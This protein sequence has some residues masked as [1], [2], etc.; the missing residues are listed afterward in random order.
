MDLVDREK[1]PKLTE[2]ERNLLETCEMPCS[3]EEWRLA[4]NQMKWKTL[5]S[6]GLLTKKETI[7]AVGGKVGE[8]D[9]KIPTPPKCAKAHPPP[10]PP[11]T[12]TKDRPR[13][14]SIK[15]MTTEVGVEKGKGKEQGK[16][17]GKEDT[18][19]GGKS[20]K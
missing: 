2:G 4:T 14:D 3:K 18:K 15:E 5:E 7:E 1:E 9:G 19:G 10:R 16:S 17:K 13:L 12:Y 8:V 6:L 20:T 11:S